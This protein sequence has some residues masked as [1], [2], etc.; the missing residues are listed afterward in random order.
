MVKDEENAIVENDKCIPQKSA[1]RVSS[2]SKYLGY[3]PKDTL[4]NPKFELIAQLMS[5][6]IKNSEAVQKA[7]PDK[8]YTSASAQRYCKCLLTKYPQILDRLKWLKNKNSEF[9][10]DE[11]RKLAVGEIEKILRKETGVKDADKIKA[12]E[13]LTRMQWIAT[14]SGRTGT[15]GKNAWNQAVQVNVNTTSAAG[16]AGQLPDPWA[17]ALRIIEARRE[18]RRQVQLVSSPAPV[19]SVIPTVPVQWQ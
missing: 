12:A 2:R 1:M 19:S 6:N 3:D 13:A 4:P 9:I 18:A 14:P 5:A 16:Q 8:N 11:L 15:Q 7:Y 17:D 10:G